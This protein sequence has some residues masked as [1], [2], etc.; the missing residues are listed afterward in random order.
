MRQL[1][2]TC[3]ARTLEVFDELVGGKSIADVASLFDAT[4]EA[5]RKTKQR[6][7]ERLQEIVAAQIADEDKPDAPR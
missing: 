5:I 3:D 2:T 6:V 1:R 4:P 7:K